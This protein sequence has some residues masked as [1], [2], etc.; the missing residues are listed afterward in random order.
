[1]S[2]TAEYFV[3]P[4][5][6]RPIVGA[7]GLLFVA[8]GAAAWL[9]EAPAGPYALGAGALVLAYVL[10]GWFTSVINEGRRGLYDDQ[11]EASFRTGMAWLIFS[12]VVVFGALFATL[13]Y[14]R[15]VSIPDLAS[16]ETHTLLWPAFKAGWPASGPDIVGPVSAMKAS[17]VP[18]IN[19]LMLL[20]SGVMITLAHAALKK[21][22]RGRLMAFLLATI[23]IGVLFL[24]NQASEY[25][26]AY[27]ALHLTLTTGAYGATFFILTGLHGLHVAIGTAFLIVMLER[28][29]RG[30]F[31]PKHHVGFLLATWYWHFVGVV[32]LILFV[33]VYL[34]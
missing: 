2:V 7:T 23:I 12:E 17:G 25:Y 32:W 26:H 20:T 31:T 18:T 10:V 34:L 15:L 3:P 5:S 6:R 29:L 21:G 30:D 19:T 4:P 27:T 22:H 28:I 33:L 8:L 1:M 24:R 13:F 11:V 9:N 14:L 16:G